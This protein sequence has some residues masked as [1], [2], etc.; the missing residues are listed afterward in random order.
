MHNTR[1]QGGTR[2]AKGF[3][4][5]GEIVNRRFKT[6]AG[7]RGFAVTR[8]LTAWPEMVGEAF[9]LMSEPVELTFEP[10]NDTVTL[11]LLSPG[12]YAEQV[13]MSIPNIRDRVNSVYGY[14]AVQCIKVAQSWK[15]RR[16]RTQAERKESTNSLTDLS[17]RSRVPL[18]TLDEVSNEKL[19]KSLFELGSLIYAKTQKDGEESR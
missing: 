18:E 11:I 5:A 7:K 13:R 19:K 12:V 14:E 4:H 3:T 16:A 8:L 17:C 10:Q 15:G 1:K 2:L 9:A 6:E